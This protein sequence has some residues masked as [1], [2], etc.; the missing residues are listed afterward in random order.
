M[1]KEVKK[2]GKKIVK[3][4]KLKL[5]E[6]IYLILV[7]LLFLAIAGYTIYRFSNKSVPVDKF[8][9]VKDFAKGYSSYFIGGVVI[10]VLLVAVI[11][12]VR[13]K[14]KNR[15]PKKIKEEKV[16]KKVKKKKVNKKLMKKI[17]SWVIIIIGLVVLSGIIYSFIYYNL[18]DYVKAFWVV[19]YPYILMGIGILAI[20]L[21]ILHFQSKKMS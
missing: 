16:A 5:F 10:L 3:R 18:I 19:Y 1:K 9:L 11:N 12:F 8:V 6:Y 13:K 7:I 2:V 20:L 4:R 15:G 21:L 17:R 14:R